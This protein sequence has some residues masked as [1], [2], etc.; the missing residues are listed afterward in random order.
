MIRQSEKRNPLKQKQGLGD[1]QKLALVVIYYFA[2]LGA[3]HMLEAIQPEELHIIDCAFDRYIPFMEIFVVPYL[4]WFVYIGSAALYFFLRERDMYFRLVY[5]GMV[6]MTI[7]LLISW[8]YPNGLELRPETFAR[9][10]VFVTWTKM[11]YA[12]DTPTNVLPSIHV[13]NSVGT[14]FAV[15]QSRRLRDRHVIKAGA[16]IL[17]LLIILSTMFLKQHSIVDVLLALVISYLAYELIYDNL[18]DR[19]A[20]VLRRQ[21]NALKT[22]RSVRD[23]H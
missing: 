2:Y 4:L 19:A 3:F 1:L 6:G 12:N 23:L 22:R 8:L 10:N 17:T 18:Y 20:F 15:R 5:T 13:F 21:V 11:V 9:D 16:H 14:L 7:F